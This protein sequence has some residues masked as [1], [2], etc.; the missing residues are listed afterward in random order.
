MI[1][2]KT[3]IIKK[4]NYLNQSDLTGK[5]FEDLK[6]KKKTNLPTLKESSYAHELIFM[7]FK[8][9]FTSKKKITNCSIT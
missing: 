8:K 5:I 1:K 2:N 6:V 9:Y 7:S 3:K 4:I